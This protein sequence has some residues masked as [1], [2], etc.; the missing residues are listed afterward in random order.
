MAQI[1]STD[2]FNPQVMTDTVRGA[3][4]AKNAFVGSDL[5]ALGIASVN[6]SMPRGGPSAIGQTIEV[7]YFGVIGEFADNSE[8]T[9]V[10]PT[11]FGQ[12]YEQG[13]IKRQSLA[14][15]VS[16]WAQGNA[17]VDPAVGDPYMEAADQI[18]MAAQRAID[19]QLVAAAAA[20]GV[21]TK[22]TYSATTPKFLDY[23]TVVDAG[24]NGFG[25]EGTGEMALLVH[26]RTQAD[27]MKLKDSTGRHLL[28]MNET[29]GGQVMRFNGKRVV[30][31]DKAPLTSSSMGSVTSS[32]TSP[33][34]ATLTGTPLG[35]WDLQIDCNLGG[36]HTTATFRFSVDGGNTWSETITTLGV[37]VATPLIDTAKDSLV[38]LNGKTG[39]SVAFAAGTFNADNLWTSTALLQAT[40]M[41][42]RPGALVFWY[43]S[44]HLG[45]E[46]D[47]DIMKHTDLAAMHLYGVAHRYRRARGGS[48]PGVTL[49]KHNVSGYTG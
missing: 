31:S 25:D 35:A 11:A 13:T 9:A 14:F 37:G 23:D 40:S 16:R 28:V 43:A 24:A 3:F 19:A 18:R 32:G 2:L 8:G 12:G 1:S 7:P 26:S 22:T 38:G 34:V 30:V 49:I 6:G 10:T 47:K 39:I 15:E 21:Y 41:L 27:L 29:E 46:T 5:V 45:L 44:E 48:Y 42:L 4:R 17:A 33:P 20:S 36:A